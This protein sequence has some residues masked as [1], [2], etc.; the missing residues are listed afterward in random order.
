MKIKIAIGGLLALL[1]AVLF[2]HVTWKA[3]GQT[4]LLQQAYDRTVGN[5][6]FKSLKIFPALTENPTNSL[7]VWDTYQTNAFQIGPTNALPIIWGYG[8]NSTAL[9]FAD[10]IYTNAAG[11]TRHLIIRNGLIMNTSTF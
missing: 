6:T 7:Q 8:S 2:T 3:E 1:L 5:W 11:T 4:N 10:V 9:L